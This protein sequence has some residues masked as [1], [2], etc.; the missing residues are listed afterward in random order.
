V[1]RS[2]R[3]ILEG[4][5]VLDFGGWNALVDEFASDAKSSSVPSRASCWQKTESTGAMGV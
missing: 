3:K 1:V 4:R 2:K 5:N